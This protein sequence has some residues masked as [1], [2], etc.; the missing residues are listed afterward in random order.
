MHIGKGV[1]EQELTLLM[2]AQI[3]TTAWENHLPRNYAIPERTQRFHLGIRIR[4]ASSCSSKDKHECASWH[5]LKQQQQ[6]KEKTQTQ[7]GK[8][9]NNPCLSIQVSSRK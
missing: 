5:Y 9:G 7:T 6:Q 3:R 8:T 1:E 4:T 2:G